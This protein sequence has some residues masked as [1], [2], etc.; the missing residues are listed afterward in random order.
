MV[1]QEP[2]ESPI[3]QNPDENA[4]N[5]DPVFSPR[6]KSLVA[7]AGWDEESILV[8][9]LI[10][11]DTPDRQIKQRKRSDTQFKT[12]PSNTSRRVQR[13]SPVSISI[14][15]INLDEENEPEKPEIQEIKVETKKNVVKEDDKSKKE[16]SEV[17]CSNSSLPCMDKLKEELSCAICLEICF[18][19]STT[20]CGHSFC[21]KCLRS[22]ADKCGKK[23][24]KCRQLI[25]NGRSCTVNTVLW[26]TIQLLFPQEVEA[27]K[28]AAVAERKTPP[29][30]TNTDVRNRNVRP[31]MV[32][33]SSGNESARRSGLRSQDHDS[34]LAQRSQREDLSRLLSSYANGISRRAEQNRDDGAEFGRIV[35]RDDVSRVIR[36][37]ATARR[38]RGTPSQ[39]E[40]AALALRLQRDEFMDA[41][42]G[43]T[44]QHSGSSVSSARENFRA[45][46]ARAVSA[47]MTNLR[48]HAT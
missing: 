39:D 33:G 36:R 18:E 21:K 40:D 47:R 29:T 12:P 15:V 37:D 14:P 7:M 22:A 9:S 13:K 3:D 23:C 34:A 24:P 38:R 4:Q 41:F 10:V 5:L 48:N 42:R 2:K 44:H 11:E 45:M 31:Y 32:S 43:G 35:Q 27:R 25:S 17:S 28:A 26:N 20:S 16:N 1:S 30:R 8:A 6:F 46:A 19:P